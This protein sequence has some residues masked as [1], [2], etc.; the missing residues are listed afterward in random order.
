VAEGGILRTFANADD[1][2]PCQIW[3][4]YVMRVVD[5]FRRT[6]TVKTDPQTD[7][8]VSLRL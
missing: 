1:G 3:Q 5:A 2:L 7:A 6:N 8:Q 4:I